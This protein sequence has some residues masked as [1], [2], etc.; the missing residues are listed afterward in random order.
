MSEPKYPGTP[1]TLGGREF[2]VPKMALRG[3]RLIAERNVLVALSNVTEGALFTTAQ[4][5][6][7]TDLMHAALA[8][9][10]PAMSRDDVADL[11]EIRDLN[12]ATI[13]AVLEAAGLE[14]KR[15]GEPASPTVN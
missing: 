9:N 14:E 12:A 7:L 15:A 10:Y 6:A 5:D 13:R 4:I 11:V 2:V 1:L 3:L 8:R